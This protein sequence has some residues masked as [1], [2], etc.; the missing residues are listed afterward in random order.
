MLVDNI[1][2]KDVKECNSDHQHRHVDEQGFDDS[3]CTEE[4]SVSDE[5]DGDSESDNSASC[6]QY[7]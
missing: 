6:Q 7:D 4:I 5:S 3:I 1:G 2:I